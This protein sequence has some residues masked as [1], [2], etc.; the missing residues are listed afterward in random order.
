MADT[1]RHLLSGSGRSICVAIAGQTAGE[2][3]ARSTALLSEFPFQEFRLDY[4][5]EPLTALPALC[6]HLRAQPDAV[7]LAT[8][9]RVPSGGRFAGIPEAELQVLLE[10]ARGGFALVDLA[11][12]SAEALPEDAAGQLRTAGA[13]V[14]LSWHDFEGTGD[15][16]T[17]LERMRPF[18][19]DLCKIV[20][21]AN[22][23]GD[24]LPL[25]QVFATAR[26][27]GAD[28]VGISMGE[29][30]VLTRVLGLR[31]GSAFTF[32]AATAEEATA[33]G[34]LAAPT[35]RDLYRVERIDTDTRVYGV[36]GDPIRSSL[37]P[38][39][40]NTAFQ[41]AGV[42]AVYLPL[43]THDAE[44]LFRV[45]RALP[46]AGFS[47]TMPLKQAVLPFLDHLDPLAAKI[48]AVNTVRREADGSYSGFNTDAAGITA[49]LEE[50][51][52]L[53]GARILVLGAGGAARA[54]VFA[55]A[56]AGAAVTILNRT[57]ATG[58]RLAGEAGAACLAQGDLAGAMPFDV[59]INATPAGMRGNETEM[60]LGTD[61]L[62]AKLVFDL[63]YN[64]TE[65]PLL[66]AARSLGIPTISGVEMFIHQGAQQFRRWTGRP[67]PTEAMRDVVIRA[68]NQA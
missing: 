2:I 68:L 54:A 38:L 65:T 19:P 33:P 47:V 32:A 66:R 39:M 7:F 59:L 5:P 22:T 45:A 21:T 1:V 13:R 56:A 3:I 53:S 8:C 4:L 35:L 28:A 46:L 41:A 31:A 63:V 36:A 24:S 48:G 49:P 27:N 50:R 34:Q 16:R 42:N 20:P 17:V 43:L 64:P 29:A 30:G 44:D 55:C 67:A 61:E 25:L 12:E 14:L 52:K 23:L 62:R 10:A 15:L 11:I 57:P 60:P 40:L 58:A 9:R 26:K 51:L 37:S 18:A 6:A